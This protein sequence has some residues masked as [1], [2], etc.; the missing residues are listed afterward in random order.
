MIRSLLAMR[1]RQQQLLRSSVSFVAKGLERS[2]F[3]DI[4]KGSI[5]REKIRNIPICVR[6]AISSSTEVQS[7]DISKN[8]SNTNSSN[9]KE[10]NLSLR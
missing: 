4:N 7:A 10:K 5:L 2:I 9:S 6:V 3:G 8:V 1:S